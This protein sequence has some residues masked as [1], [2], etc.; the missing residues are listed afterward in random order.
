MGAAS[1]YFVELASAAQNELDELRAFDARPIVKAIRVLQH[2]AET[3]TRNRKP[4]RRPIAGLA[5]A[6]WEV[7]VGDYR[8]LY[9]VRNERVV[10]VLRVIL[11]GRLTTEEAADGNDR[12]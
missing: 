7:R 3:A 8:V 6:S 9:E 12:E 10:R 5:D 4:L 1:R 2:E 11:K